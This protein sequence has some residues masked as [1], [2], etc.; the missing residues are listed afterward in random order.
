MPK[1]SRSVTPIC[2]GV[3][4]FLASLQMWSHTSSVFIFNQVGALRRYGS[5]EDEMPLPLP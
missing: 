5:A 2:D 3:R 4:P 1:L